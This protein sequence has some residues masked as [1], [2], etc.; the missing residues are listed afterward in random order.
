MFCSPKTTLALGRFPAS[1][2]YSAI[3][4]GFA[5]TV[6][7]V[8]PQSTASESYI[9]VIRA[10][11]SDRLRLGQRTDGSVAAGTDRG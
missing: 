5:A 8:V 9:A 4:A 10:K 11:D 7:A 6:F 2:K 3:A 1:W